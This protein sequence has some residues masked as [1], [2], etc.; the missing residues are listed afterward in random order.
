MKG[1]IN[2]FL[3]F[4]PAGIGGLVIS[5][6]GVWDSL[7]DQIALAFASAITALQ[8]PLIAIGA[9][10]V[11]VAYVAAIVFTNEGNPAQLQA[12][13]EAKATVARQRRFLITVG[14]SLSNGY[15]RSND[16]RTLL[17]FMQADGGYAR[18]RP[19]FSK[20]FAKQLERPELDKATMADALLNEMDRL[21]RKWQLV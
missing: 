21:E 4:A 15:R 16:N 5:A 13:A 12:T 18:I 8:H 6:A 14:R 9:G 11:V 20:A 10:L 2:K 7:R 19:H 1:Q 17:E 3:I